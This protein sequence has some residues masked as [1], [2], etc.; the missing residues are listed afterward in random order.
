MN[1]EYKIDAD[2]LGA[3]TF[4][5]GRILISYQ[6]GNDYGVLTTDDVKAVGTYESLDL[7]SP[8]KRSIDITN[9]K[10]AEIFCEPLPAG[11]SITMYYK[12]NKTGSVKIW[13][14]D[15]VEIEPN[16]EQL[17]SYISQT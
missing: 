5:D 13:S 8:V 4:T 6:D 14:G 9:W 11:S 10:T 15:A 3:V 1:C 17:F 12:L 7:K 2:E 16:K